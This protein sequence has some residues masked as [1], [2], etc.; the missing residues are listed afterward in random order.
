MLGLV[1]LD[2]RTIM[3]FGKVTPGGA[4]RAVA[5][6]SWPVAESCS[7]LGSWFSSASSARP[8][9]QLLRCRSREPLGVVWRWSPPWC[10]CLRS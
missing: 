7:L 2:P 4:A 6:P 3:A 8:D 5:S 9:D 1:P 10:R